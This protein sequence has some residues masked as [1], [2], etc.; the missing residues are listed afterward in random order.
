VY[1]HLI[2]SQHISSL[3]LQVPKYQPP[4]LNHS[5]L[6]G[7][8][9]STFLQLSNVY[10][11]FHRTSATLFS[12]TLHFTPQL[13]CKLFDQLTVCFANSSGIHFLSKPAET[14]RCKATHNETFQEFCPLYTHTL[15][16]ECFSPTQ[17]SSLVRREHFIVFPTVRLTKSSDNSIFEETKQKQKKSNQIT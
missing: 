4:S 14:K 15:V 10:P 8:P 2:S 1:A 9:L 12:N 13:I 16:V 17:D 5:R 11:S 6:R 3:E 7:C